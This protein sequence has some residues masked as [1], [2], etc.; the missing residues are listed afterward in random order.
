MIIVVRVKMAEVTVQD[1]AIK[2]VPVEICT[3]FCNVFPISR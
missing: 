3:R 2:R 1:D